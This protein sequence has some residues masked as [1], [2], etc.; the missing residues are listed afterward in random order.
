MPTTPTGMPTTPTAAAAMQTTPTMI[1]TVT[2]TDGVLLGSTGSAEPV[3]T[4]R[5]YVPT[6]AWFRVGDN[7]DFELLDV[8]APVDGGRLYV[9]EK[10]W[11]HVY[12]LRRDIEK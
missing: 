11:L 12:V 7:K 2:H 3:R 6:A 8:S 1:Y 4:A 5:Q 10:G 9:D